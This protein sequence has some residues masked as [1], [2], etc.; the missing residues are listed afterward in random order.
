[1]TFYD[2][3]DEFAARCGITKSLSKE[4]CLQMLDV[5]MEAIRAEDPIR[6]YG[7]GSLIPFTRKSKPVKSVNTGE[8]VDSKARKS[9]RFVL[10][11][12]FEAE[13]NEELPTANLDA[14]LSE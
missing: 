6:I 14:L 5:I 12:K 13:L 2:I 10:G 9:V 3:V 11:D 8:W 4:L 1:M 7:F